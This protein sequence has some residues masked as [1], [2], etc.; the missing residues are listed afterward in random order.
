MSTLESA[1][2][3]ACA[4]L[5]EDRKLIEA[6]AASRRGRGWFLDN[7]TFERIDVSDHLDSVEVEAQAAAN[8]CANAGLP[9]LADC[10]KRIADRIALA[11]RQ[12]TDDCD[13]LPDVSRLTTAGREAL[14]HHKFFAQ[15]FL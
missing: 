6:F 2:G 9:T 13:A 15:H 3:A 7:Y 4:L 14:A 8:L 1:L 5:T 10:C 12:G 11:N